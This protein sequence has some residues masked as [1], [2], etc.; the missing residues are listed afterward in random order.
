MQKVG[1]FTSSSLHEF[2]CDENSGKMYVFVCFEAK[3]V[4]DDFD[5]SLYEIVNHRPF[6]SRTNLYRVI[7]VE[8]RFV[9]FFAISNGGE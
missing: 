1:E 7:Q 6:L 3:C 5:L 2:T 9:I 4:L 8:T